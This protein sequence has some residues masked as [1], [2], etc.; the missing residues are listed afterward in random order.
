VELGDKLGEPESLGSAEG[1]WLGSVES[2]GEVVGPVLGATLGRDDGG[3][4]GAADSVGP[5]LGD[6]LG[7]ELG[8]VDGPTLGEELSDGT[9]LGTLLGINESLGSTGLLLGAADLV[10]VELGV[11]LGF[12]GVDEGP[13]LVRLVG[14]MDIGIVGEEEGLLFCR[15]GLGLSVG[16]I[17]G[18]KDTV[19]EKVGEDVGLFVGLSD[20]ELLGETVSVGL[21]LPDVLGCG[22]TVGANVGPG[23]GLFVNGLK[24]GDALGATLG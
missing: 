14:S 7:A 16:D 20:G 19:G 12:E 21:P 17:V 15:S 18:L 13:E 22:E 3:A 24:L 1:L 6:T 4:L 2:E 5:E 9:S 23:V 11:R 10:G 8:A